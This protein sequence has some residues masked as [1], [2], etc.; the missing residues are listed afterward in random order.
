MEEKNKKNETENAAAAATAAS[1]DP[2]FRLKK[3]PSPVGDTP[4]SSD[5]VSQNLAPIWL[6]HCP[7]WRATISRMVD[8]LVFNGGEGGRKKKKKREGSERGLGDEK[9]LFFVS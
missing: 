1:T 3:T 4:C 2:A 7:A 6:P 5:S 9:R 8:V